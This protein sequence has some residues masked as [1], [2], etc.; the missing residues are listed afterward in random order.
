MIEH[1]NSKLHSGLDCPDALL[2]STPQSL[3]IESIRT[4]PDLWLSPSSFGKRSV[5]ASKRMLLESEAYFKVLSEYFSATK[6]F[7]ICEFLRYGI[8]SIKS[9][10]PRRQVRRLSKIFSRSYLW[11]L[12][13]LKHITVRDNLQNG[14]GAY[15]PVQP[16]LIEEV[17]E[18]IGSHRM[19]GKL[20]ELL[21][22][23]HFRL[24]NI[25]FS[26]TKNFASHKST[27]WHRDSVGNRIKIFV[28]IG[29]NGRVPATGYIPGSHKSNP[30]SN[31]LDMIR[32]CMAHRSNWYIQDEIEYC[33]ANSAQFGNSSIFMQ[34]EGDILLVD[35]NGY[36]KSYMPALEKRSGDS[37]GSRALLQL[38][39]MR[40]DISDYVH[41]NNIGPC[42]PGQVPIFLDPAI[43]PQCERFG[44]DRRHLH[45]PSNSSHYKSHVLYTVANR[46]DTLS[47]SYLIL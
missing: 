15:W 25:H 20:I 4:K 16:D 11:S 36:H 12:E 47:S 19:I 26:L 32:A 34:Q 2:E 10:L 9:A 1:L 38:E 22:S 21:L 3:V 8:Q 31:N 6:E 14:H 35:T 7:E 46:L 44:I 17:L 37:H 33:L 40:S 13:N 41:N 30:I 24:D 28:C 5:T 23:K 27:H 45:K 29:A 42:A 43:L 39:Y 18:S